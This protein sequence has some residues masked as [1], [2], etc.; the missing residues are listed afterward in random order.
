MRDRATQLPKILITVLFIGLILFY[1]YDRSKNLLFGPQITI[2]HPQNGETIPDDLITIRGTI[3]N[4]SEIRLNDRQIFANED[5]YFQEDVLLHYG[6]NVI[7]ITA[8]DRFGQQEEK[9]LQ[10]VY[11]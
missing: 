2:E 11:Q 10:L 4:A 9:I 6:Y 1:A 7:E 5:N 8:T 3:K